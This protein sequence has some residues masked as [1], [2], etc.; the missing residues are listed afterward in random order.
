M[1]H[2]WLVTHDHTKVHP[3][4]IGKFENFQEIKKVITLINLL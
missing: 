4:S 2:T 1:T 3:L